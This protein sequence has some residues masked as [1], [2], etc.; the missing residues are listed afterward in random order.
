VSAIGFW[1]ARRTS[2]QIVKEP[3]PNLETFARAAELCSF[4]KAARAL[5]LT[6]AAVSQRI[7]AL[8]KEVRQ[9]LFERQGGRVLL[10]D[11]GRRLYAFAQQILALHDEARQTLAGEKRAIS[12][13]LTLAASSVPGEH[14]LPRLLTAFRERFPGIQVKAS[15]L[16]SQAVLKLL[17]QGEA[18]LGL[19][20]RKS[21]SPHLEFRPIAGDQMTLIVAPKS[22]W[23]H[24]KT[25]PLTK[26]RNV[27]LI[28]R[29]KGSGSRS[30]L[31]QT[32][33]HSGLSLADLQVVL[34]L[35]SNEAIK[36]AV[37]EGLGGSI[38]SEHVV[39]KELHSRQ[40][41]AVTIE[42]LSLER[43]FYLAWDRRRVLAIPAQHFQQFV[44]ETSV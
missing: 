37:L 35:S 16:D 25:V 39:R 17:E 30:C 24:G 10:S 18:E 9:A 32:L 7:G 43:S 22:S 3:L 26:L 12:G 6:Q 21:D 19:V 5:G 34:E 2:D 15:V 1:I 23:V 11:A 27:P 31:E 42:G 40:L 33:E 4:T 20:G 14:L 28:I 36:E 41:R 29:E 13:E 44:L 38:L 8:E